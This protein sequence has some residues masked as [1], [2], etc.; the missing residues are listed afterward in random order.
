MDRH[1]SALPPL[2]Q[3]KR[4][5]VAIIAFLKFHSVETHLF[6]VLGMLKFVA[7]VSKK[8]TR[9]LG[10]TNYDASLTEWFDLLGRDNG[11]F[12]TFLTQCVAKRRLGETN[13]EASLKKELR[14]LGVEDFVRKNNR[15]LKRKREC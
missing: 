3:K 12:V 9:R 15:N 8:M 4:F 14:T 7:F 10:E 5:D 1:Q 2:E 6:D 13:Y 11:I